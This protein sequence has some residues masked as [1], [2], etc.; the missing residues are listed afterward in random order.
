MFNI[1][2]KKERMNLRFELWAKEKTNDKR[3]RMRKLSEMKCK[4]STMLSNSKR[5]EMKFRKARKEKK[6][7]KSTLTYEKE[8]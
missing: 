4:R 5:N 7:S 1:K 3:K 6:T 8:I 2:R